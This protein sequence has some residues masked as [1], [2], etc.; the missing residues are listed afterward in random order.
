MTETT[1][2]VMALKL[3]LRLEQMEG[4]FS[5]N[6]DEVKRC[7]ILMYL[8]SSKEDEFL[9]IASLYCASKGKFTVRSEEL[10]DV[11]EGTK[12]FYKE[13]ENYVFE[14][15]GLTKPEDDTDEDQ[16]DKI[17]QMW[18]TENEDIL[19]KTGLYT[20]KQATH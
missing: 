15:G 4:S 2:L 7:A 14:H 6:E 16:Y 13:C 12:E 3:N 11:V 8:T 1:V 17:L 9:T 10:N 19:G 5:L 18:V 20:R